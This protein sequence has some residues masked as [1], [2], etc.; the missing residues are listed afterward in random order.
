MNGNEFHFSLDN[1]GSWDEKQG[2]AFSVSLNSCNPNVNS[3]MKEEICELIRYQ[4][5]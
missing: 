2:L 3:T 4:T 1:Q 5:V